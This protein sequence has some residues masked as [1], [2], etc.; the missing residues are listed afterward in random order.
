MAS[1][2]WLVGMVSLISVNLAWYSVL[3]K[4]CCVGLCASLELWVF[5]WLHMVTI[6]ALFVVVCGCG[7]PLS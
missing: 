1:L 7:F 6:E 4:G 5:P 3:H 2:L